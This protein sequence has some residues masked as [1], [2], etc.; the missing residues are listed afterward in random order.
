MNADA[1]SQE[2]MRLYRI[3]K[4]VLKMLS[5]RGYN[6]LD[7]ALDATFQTFAVGV[8]VGVGVGVC[9]SVSVYRSSGCRG[10][11]GMQVRPPPPH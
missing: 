8:G 4:T 1:Q 5:K 11:A 9:M 6:V 2:L 3:R 7:Q 10:W